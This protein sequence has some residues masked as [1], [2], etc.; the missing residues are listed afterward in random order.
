MDNPPPELP[1]HLQL[2]NNPAMQPFAWNPYNL[3]EN[4]CVTTGLPS[5]PLRSSFNPSGGIFN[6]AV[7][8]PVDTTSYES[9]LWQRL[10]ALSGYSSPT[11]Y[12]YA[13]P[14]PIPFL[15]ASLYGQSLL[16]N[17]YTLQ[18]P[19]Q[20]KIINPAQ[21]ASLRN[22]Y[23]GSTGTDLMIS[24]NRNSEPRQLPS[25]PQ[26]QASPVFQY[27]VPLQQKF[28]HESLQLQNDLNMPGQYQN[29]GLQQ[30]QIVGSNSAQT[31]NSGTSSYPQAKA[32]Q[33]PSVA[34][35]KIIQNQR[36]KS[37]NPSTSSRAE[38][39]HFIKPLPQMGTL[40]TTDADGRLR[41][42]VP[43]PSDGAEDCRDLLANLKIGNTLRP[44]N[45]PAITRTTSERVPN[46]SE[47][48]SQVQRTI[49]ARHTTK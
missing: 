42:I 43:V 31:V 6:F 47:L 18:P 15:P 14:Q 8:P 49:W 48:M 41:V 19:P 13:L 39:A 21:V 10:Q 4:R 46:R 2:D 40:T 45:G 17:N 5:S 38:S 44:S 36:E 37:P 30:T 12:P 28:Q 25:T 24:S 20:K 35:L 11:L 16:N 7:Q 27:S 23:P 22:S 1:D 9:Q 32:T 34:N 33:S 3:I 26:Y 29:V